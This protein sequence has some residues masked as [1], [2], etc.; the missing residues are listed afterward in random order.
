[1]DLLLSLGCQMVAI[2]KFPIW[3]QFG[4]LWSGTLCQL[5]NYWPFGI[6]FQGRYGNP[7]SL[8]P[9][10]AFSSSLSE[11][12]EIQESLFS[13]TWGHADAVTQYTRTY[14][15]VVILATGT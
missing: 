12:H 6:L 4:G 13:S 5:G 3:V 9:S 7:V 15:V 2:P 14:L 10:Q 8:F 1:M 11:L